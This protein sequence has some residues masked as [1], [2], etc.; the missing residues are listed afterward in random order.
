MFEPKYIN[1]LLT[2]KLS[3]EA[4]Q[5]FLRVVYSYVRKYHWPKSIIG[6]ERF[7]SSDFWSNEEIQELT[8]SFFEWIIVKRKLDYLHKVP[9]RYLSYYFAQILISFVADCIKIE[10]EKNSLS[11]QRCKD[12]I[13]ELIKEKLE[14]RVIDGRE[15]V[16]EDSFEKNDLKPLDYVREALKYYTKMVAHKGKKQL[17]SYVSM[18]VEDVFMLGES[19]IEKT[20]L[21]KIVYGLFDHN[22]LNDRNEEPS[23]EISIEDDLSHFDEIIESIIDGFSNSDLRMI[24]TYLFKNESKSSLDELSSEFGIPKSSLHYK[25]DSFKKKIFNSYKPENEKDG[26]LFIKRIS[27]YLDKT[28]K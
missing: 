1:D 12:I 4:Y 11:F 18:V 14:L 5:H 24:D 17:K 25:I 6:N 10:Q 9:Q 8:H 26:V 23:S 16:F 15:Y 2:G 3:G 27:E 20:E 7:S 22:E 21:A 19:P 28:L 13:S